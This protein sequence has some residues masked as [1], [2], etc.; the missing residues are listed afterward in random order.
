MFSWFILRG[1][2]FRL[3][4]LFEIDTLYSIT[5][6]LFYEFYAL[7]IIRSAVPSYIPVLIG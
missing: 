6:K 2:T 3:F 5:P 7:V 1:E 4:I